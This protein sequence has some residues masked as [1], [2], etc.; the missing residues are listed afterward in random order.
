MLRFLSKPA[1]LSY[2]LLAGIGLRIVLY[3]FIST[4]V[5]P[6]QEVLEFIYVRHRLP[7]TRELF[8]ATHPPLYYLLALPF[9]W[10]DNPQT[11]K[12]T[13][14]F[15]LLISCLNLYLLYRLCLRVFGDPAIRAAAFV[16]AVFSY[17][18]VASS[19][20]VSNDAL[21]F[22]MGTACILVLH[23][24]IETPTSGNELLLAILTGLALLTKST[25]LVFVP[26]MTLVVVFIRHRNRQYGA[27]LF[28]ALVAF[29]AIVAVVGGYKFLEN[30]YYEH[31]FLAHNLD[32][33]PLPDQ[34]RTYQGIGTVLNWNLLTLID[35]PV[36]WHGHPSRHNY[37][38]QLYGSFWY[39][40]VYFEN[41]LTFSSNTWFRR[42]GS[43]LYALALLPS[44]VI[45]LGVGVLVRRSI[46]FVF[47]GWSWSEATFRQ[48]LFTSAAT[49][50]LLLSFA[51]LVAAGVKYD[52]W[53]FFHPRLFLHS[54]FSVMLAFVVGL[55]WLIRWRPALGSLTIRTLGVLAIAYV[56]YFGVE[57]GV[58]V[59]TYTRYG[60]SEVNWY[61]EDWV[62]ERLM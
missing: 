47:Q 9:Y 44:L 52:S 31:R 14:F 3:A 42:M 6:H 12:L 22:L 38:M 54:F 26:V 21:A 48:G 37:F 36:F 18:Y 51:F 13:Q 15:S 19:L 43:L 1:A 56:A 8:S 50:L 57:I 23:R 25:L 32:F 5:D 30:R 17:T 35:D 46:R 2:L 4:G 7:H 10:F 55:E 20:Y 45:L 27:T 34:E 62:R 61:I 49:A 58:K 40:H 16:L 59:W 39:K 60:D 28:L 29:L 33:F 24:Y 11:L 53:T 41:N